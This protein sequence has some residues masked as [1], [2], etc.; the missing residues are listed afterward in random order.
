V[1]FNVPTQRG[2]VFHR[3]AG[4]T[5]LRASLITGPAAS[6][7]DS[8]AVE[9]RAGAL[10][11]LAINPNQ[12]RPLAT[13]LGNRPQLALVGDY[14]AAGRYCVGANAAWATADPAVA[15]VRQGLL[16]TLTTGGTA[17]TATIGTVSDSLN[18][19]VGSPTL[20][21]VEVTPRA[22]SVARWSTSRMRALAHYSDGTVDDVSANPS[23]LW[24]SS[25]LSGT[26]V[27]LVDPG[28]LERGL[29]WAYAPGQARVDACIGTR[30]ASAAPDRSGVVTVTP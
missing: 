29:I 4:T 22:L 6:L 25:V 7:S 13:A 21:F 24:S 19:V 9:V 14:G 11:G 23:T 27:L 17:V 1:V 20:T 26:G 8:V 18:V 30:C 10:A 2:V 5:L 12:A 16:T 3:A 15:T 28:T